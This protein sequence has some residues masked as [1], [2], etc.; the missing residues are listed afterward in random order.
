MNTNK[1]NKLFDLLIKQDIGVG[2]EYKI[3]VY[4]MFKEIKGRIT[5]DQTR[6]WKMTKQIEEESSKTFIIEK[7]ISLWS[8]I[9]WMCC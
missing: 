7:K 3:I 2:E 4:D 1:N 9:Q 5:N 6:V 8:K